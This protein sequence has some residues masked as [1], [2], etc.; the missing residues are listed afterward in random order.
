[1]TVAPLETLDSLLTSGVERKK[2][3]LIVGF[4]FLF[5]FKSTEAIFLWEGQF[6]GLG[7]IRFCR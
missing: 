4:A 1:M 3:N 5:W 6:W 7:P 2:A